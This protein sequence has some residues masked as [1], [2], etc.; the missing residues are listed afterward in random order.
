MEPKPTSSQLGTRSNP[1][2]LSL[3]PIPV[4]HGHN[5]FL[6]ADDEPVT[7]SSIIVELGDLSRSIVPSAA[8]LVQSIARSSTSGSCDSVRSGSQTSIETGSDIAIERHGREQRRQERREKRRDASA[9]QR[10]PRRRGA[11]RP[12]VD[13]GIDLIKGTERGLAS[14]RINR[15]FC[16]MDQQTV[17]DVKEELEVENKR[18]HQWVS[19]LQRVERDLLTERQK[20]KQQLEIQRQQHERDAKL[21]REALEQK[22]KQYQGR[23]HEMG[24]Q[25]LDL[26][27]QKLRPLVSNL[28]ISN[29]FADQDAA[30]NAWARAYGHRDPTRL[31]VGLHPA[32]LQQICDEVKGFVQ[33]TNVGKLPPAILH[34]GKEAVHTLLQAMLT[35][36]FC[37]EIL[38]SPLWVFTAT[39][40]GTLESPNI[41]P[42]RSFSSGI[43]M[44]M[45]MF[46]D[47]APLRPA[48]LPQPPKS[49][50]FPPPLITTMVPSLSIGSNASALGLPTRTEME[51]MHAMLVDAQDP[52]SASTPEAQSQWLPHLLRSLA[53]AGLALPSTPHTS[54]L[55]PSRLT[56]IDSRLNLARKLRDSFLGSAARFL[57]NDQDAAGIERLERVLT[58][59]IDD[60]LRFSIK[61]WSRPGAGVKI[62]SWRD[63]VKGTYKTES[64]SSGGAGG[65]PRVGLCHLQERNKNE[66]YEG[67]PVV[68][69]SQPGVEEGE[70]EKGKPGVVWLKAR[71]MVAAVVD[72]DDSASESGFAPSPVESREATPL[73]GV[74]G[75]EVIKDSPPSRP[76]TPKA[77]ETLP[78]AIYMGPAGEKK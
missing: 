63:V 7:P 75:V 68:M 54:N 5:H 61:L 41:L 57:L 31:S 30:W 35:N 23:I 34:G 65:K 42:P 6:D 51:R 53:T 52:A 26:T 39:S 32:Q 66:D 19:A 69:L 17:A 73:P 8:E 70:Q 21:W 15:L 60:A 71:V 1:R 78:A 11:H 38:A 25:L 50:L 58:E 3:T 72:K 33:L 77:G 44:D 18:L 36:F 49:P 46:N 22:E 55:S 29:W 40:L 4:H 59:M 2:A 45:N 27:T 74:P 76:D 14:D 24:E 12:S 64:G 28:E 43:R 47:I 48:A 56:L 37:K 62:R 9:E 20:L 13:R 67:R 16:S 10:V